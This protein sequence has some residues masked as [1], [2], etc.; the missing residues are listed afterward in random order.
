[1][2]VN[3]ISIWLLKSLIGL[4]NKIR[5]FSFA[6]DYFQI[7]IITLV[8]TILFILRKIIFMRSFAIFHQR[9]NIL[10]E[11]IFVLIVFVVLV[12]EFLEHWKLR[13]ILSLFNLKN[14]TCAQ[15]MTEIRWAWNKYLGISLV[16]CF[17]LRIIWNSRS[18]Y[19]L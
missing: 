3:L 11:R 7:F 18:Y 2:R 1:L 6:I 16:G 19:V 5:I 10:L 9:I 4:F 17:S 12:V 8:L 14:L 15:M 13:T